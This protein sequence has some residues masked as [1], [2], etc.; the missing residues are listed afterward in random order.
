MLSSKQSF[1][2]IKGS[3]TSALST[4]DLLIKIPSDK[5]RSEFSMLHLYSR[6]TRNL[7]QKN[8]AE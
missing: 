3:K 8:A 4:I 6:C 2:K 5:Q 7:S 1:T